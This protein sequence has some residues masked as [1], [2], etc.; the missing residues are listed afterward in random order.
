MANLPRVLSVFTALTLWCVLP[1]TVWAQPQSLVDHLSIRAQQRERALQ[2]YVDIHGNNPV[3]L[4]TAENKPISVYA[5]INGRPVYRVPLGLKA[6]EAVS[7]DDVWA[8]TGID[9]PISG[10]G[11]TI[12][13]WESFGY[14]R[15]THDEFAA[16]GGGSRI[17][18]LLG[19]SRST[20]GIDNH[21]T[22]VTGMAAAGG[23]NATLKGVAYEAAIDAYDD[24]LDVDEM[25]TAATAGLLVS[26]HSYG[27]ENGWGGFIDPTGNDDCSDNPI[28]PNCLPTWHGDPSISPTEDYH[29]GFYDDD[30]RTWDLIANAF[31]NYNIVLASGNDRFRD[32]GATPHWVFTGA[33][34]N[35]GWEM[36]TDPRDKDGGVDGY[37][38][39]LSGAQSA[40]NVFTV[41]A[42]SNIDGTGCPGNPVIVDPDDP[43]V[44][45]SFSSW[46]P[47][48]DGRIAPDFVAPGFKVPAPTAGSDTSSSCGGSGGTSN[49]APV[50]TGI[51][52]L[53]AEHQQNLFANTRPAA[54]YKA[55]LAQ[56]ATDLGNTGPDYQH[57]WGLP[58][59]QLAAELMQDDKDMGGDYLIHEQSLADGDTFTIA[60]VSDGTPL[61][62]TLAWNDPAGTP[63]APALNPPDL[64]LVNDLDM[65][66]NGAEGTFFPW[67]LDPANP[68]NVATRASDNF[69]DN[70]EQVLIDT[71]TAGALYT[72][73]LS[74]KGTLNGGS[75]AFS[76]VLS[77]LSELR[78]TPLALKVLLH[79]PHT[80]VGAGTMGT[81]LNTTGQLPVAH[82]Y[83]GLPWSYTGGETV[84]AG[85]FSTH[86]DLVDWVLV[87]LRTGTA[88]AT[89]VDTVAALLRSD[90][91]LMHLDGVTPLLVP[92]SGA[93]Y[94]VVRHRS[95]LDLMTSTTIDLGNQGGGVYD[96]TT[97][98]GQAFGVNP[99][100]EMESGIFG[101]YGGDG[102]AENGVTA[103]DMLQVW[104]PQNGGPVGYWSG[105]YNMNSSVTAFDILQIWLLSNG[106][107]SQVPG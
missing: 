68:G 35:D 64:M 83:T 3:P 102:N 79:G 21:S 105:D 32:R 95:H 15:P 47:T 39:M 43:L 34:T 61:R 96:L 45:T 30:S 90:G 75:Q 80:L 23:S 70:I 41:G 91:R 14:A 100:L 51:L 5:I 27:A 71:P 99:M 72:L 8:G 52:A 88:A 107:S 19:T 106:I 50:V 6:S 11:V 2:T 31:P 65:R 7:A 54:T 10:D 46:G 62:A 17:N 73:T 87:E 20:S 9:T 22:R 92:V 77:G 4:F 76:L 13:I 98:Q 37:D 104:L 69:R 101:M 29:W 42:L 38:S 93:H 84:S 82:P 78:A 1:A 67:T 24:T 18:G 94:V 81:A 55:L 16:S 97:G 58:N 26:N 25:T 28:G 103:F 60:L 40:K 44:M 48:D 57:G 86:T 53:L 63:V 74:H 12:G 49:A 56:T 33:A 66:I 89:A 85:F 59:T 36:S